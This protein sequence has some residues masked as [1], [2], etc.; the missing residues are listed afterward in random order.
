MPAWIVT[1]FLY[2]MIAYI[3]M[4]LSITAPLSSFHTVIDSRSRELPSAA[5]L[6]EGQV[7][8]L[9]DVPITVVLKAMGMESD[10]E[11]VQ[12]VGP[13]PELMDLFAAS[14]EEPCSLNIRTQLQALRH[15]GNT[16]RA[17]QAKTQS[18]GGGGWGAFALPLLA[19][20]RG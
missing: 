3:G 14:L 8:A 16:I 6:A 5:D 18:S 10:Q 17:Q 12:L 11:I 1:F 15:I 7:P 13:E 9:A 20:S 19:L 4:N 2:I